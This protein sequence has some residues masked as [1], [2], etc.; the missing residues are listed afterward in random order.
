MILEATCLRHWIDVLYAKMLKLW[1]LPQGYEDDNC[2]NQPL[3]PK[4]ACRVP[5]KK[6]LPFYNSIIIIIN[7]NIIIG[8]QSSAAISHH[9]DHH[10]HHHQQHHHPSIHPPIHP[11]HPPTHPSIHPSI[12]PSS[13]LPPIPSHPFHPFHPSS[14]SSSSSFI[15][16]VVVA[17]AIAVATMAVAGVI[18]AATGVIVLVVVG[19]GAGIVVVLVGV[20]VGVGVSVVVGV[21][22][23]VVI[24][25]VGVISVIRVGVSVSVGVGVGV[26]V[27]IVIIVVFV[28]NFNYNICIFGRTRRLRLEVCSC[29]WLQVYVQGLRLGKPPGETVEPG[30]SFLHVVTFNWYWPINA[31]FGFRMDTWVDLLIDTRWE[32]IPSG[33]ARLDLFGR[34]G[35]LDF[36]MF[37]RPTALSVLSCLFVYFGRQHAFSLYYFGCGM[38]EAFCQNPSVRKTLLSFVWRKPGEFTRFWH[39]PCFHHVLAIHQVFTSFWNFTKLKPDFTV[40]RTNF[41]KKRKTLLLVAI[42]KEV[43]FGNIWREKCKK[44]FC[45]L[46][47]IH[48]TLLW[49]VGGSLA[50]PPEAT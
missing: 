37:F 19:M 27:V 17:I 21:G 34:C 10:H 25:G 1:Q 14:P 11:T 41:N 28:Y 44:C 40:K 29:R 5:S 35:D 20:G 45:T 24:V 39:S 15:I 13:S 38:E 12:H 8:H 6:R 30:T 50:N 42:L 26:V 32:L 16:V 47:W 33:F 7:N 18:A 46:S 9:H 23:S 2:A 49:N 3:I 48:K 4:N 43:F 36:W 31:G 22:V